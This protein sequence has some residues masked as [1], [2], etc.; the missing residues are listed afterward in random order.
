MTKSKF[1]TALLSLSV[2]GLL[3]HNFY[4][5]TRIE[6]AVEYAASASSRATDA[7]EFA[8]RASSRARDAAEFAEN[9]NE[10][11]ERA[12]RYAEEAQDY[13][14]AYNCNYCP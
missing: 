7:A 9:A 3:A 11:A 6:V 2:I 1:S 14:F 5:Q 12:A 4:L 8:A 10:E 13:S